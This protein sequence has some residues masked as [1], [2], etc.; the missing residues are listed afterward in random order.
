MAEIREAGANICDVQKVNVA[1]RFLIKSSRRGF[2]VCPCCGGAY[3]LNDF[4]VKSASCS[5]HFY[6]AEVH[7]AETAFVSCNGG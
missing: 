4:I 7:L 5:D 6:F 3:P 2:T 1:Y